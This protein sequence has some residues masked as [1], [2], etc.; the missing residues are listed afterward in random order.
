MA[1]IISFCGLSCDECGAYVAT[2]NDDDAK[3]AEVA[4]MWSKEFNGD[5]KPSDINC[6]GCPST[7]GPVFMHCKVCEIRKCGLARGVA[8]C[9]HCDDYACEK[10]VAFFEMVPACRETL[11][12]IR[13]AR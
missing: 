11:D 7:E 13:K 9:A 10:L 5:I 8:N 1:R 3:R 2:V 12:G 4:E 6:G